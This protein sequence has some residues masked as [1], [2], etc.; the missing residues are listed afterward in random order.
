M[1]SNERKLFERDLAFL[2]AMREKV[3]IG[4]HELAQAIEREIRELEEILQS[5]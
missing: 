3:V 2:R 1:D 5:K 4:E